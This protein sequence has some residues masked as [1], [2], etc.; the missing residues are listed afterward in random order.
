M[1]AFSRIGDVDRV[2]VP[3]DVAVVVSPVDLVDDTLVV[4]LL[5]TVVVCD[6]DVAVV[7]ALEGARSAGFFEARSNRM[8]QSPSDHKRDTCSTSAASNIMQTCSC[9]PS[10]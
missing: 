10:G 8:D 1:D 2:L 9:S 4:R 6:V 5:V 3:L 7:V